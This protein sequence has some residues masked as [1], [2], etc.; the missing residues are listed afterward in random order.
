MK[1]V[2]AT[3][4]TA[5]A[6]VL[7]IAPH[8]AGAVGSTVVH[9]TLTSKWTPPSPDPSGLTY[10]KSA[11]HLV[12][13]DPEVDETAL[14]R[15]KNVFEATLRGGLA[16][17]GRTT[18]YARD[19]E[20]V[21]WDN[22]GEALYV[23]DDDSD[24]IYRVNPGG[25]GRFGS[26][27]DSVSTALSCHTFGVHDPEGLAYRVKD[28]SLFVADDTTQ[29]IYH[30]VRGADGN[31]GTADD[32][33]TSFDAT[34]VGMRS[35]EDV[36]FSPGSKH[37]L[38][39]SSKDQEVAETTVNGTLVRTIDI[40]SGN[41]VAPNGITVAP[42]SDARSQTHLYIVD[43]GTDNNSNPGEND[44]VLAEFRVG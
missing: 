36:E 22:N 44:G 31:F 12:I 37:L 29:R 32:K 1:R 17:T 7:T 8:S 4:A 18:P 16:Q 15:R 42:G 21:A 23:A 33:V 27:D 35:P 41:L 10:R 11:H 9:A 13:S 25:D 30:I 2:V 5:A 19:P 24:K 26:R 38:I 6:A 39:V 34:A 43:R 14:W 20:D 3:L 40:S 28:R